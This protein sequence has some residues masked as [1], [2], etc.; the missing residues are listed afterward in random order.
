M[1]NADRRSLKL[2]QSVQLTLGVLYSTRVE[3]VLSDSSCKM[4]QK[5]AYNSTTLVCTLSISKTKNRSQSTHL[6]W[7]THE[8]E[9]EGS[10]LVHLVP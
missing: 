8:S 10:L 1:L 5:V 9:H 2:W 4:N 3:N 7:T 6:C